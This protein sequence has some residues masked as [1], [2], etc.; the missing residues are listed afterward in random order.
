MT[1]DNSGQWFVLTIQ[2]I[3]GVGVEVSRLSRLLNDLSSAF[4]AIARSEIGAAGPRPGRHT[5]AEETLAGIR[6]VR[7][8]PGSAA[9]ELAPPQ[10]TD[11]PRLLP[12]E[13]TPDDVAFGFF[14]E[15]DELERGRQPHPDRWDVRKRVRAVVDDA[16]QIGARAEIVH[17]PLVQGSGAGRVF[18]RSFRTRDIP[19][20]PPLERTTRRRKLSGHTFMV[21]VEPTKQRLRL[22]LPDG[23]DLTLEADEEIAASIVAAIDHVVE[24]DVEEELEGNVS[25]R[26]VARSL[27]VLP[28]SG[29]GSDRPPKSI[30]ELEHEQDLGGQQP[31]YVS[32]ASAVWETEQELR[33]FERHLQ[34]IRRVDTG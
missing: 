31:D 30:E 33:E 1:T 20:V 22:K 15:I 11:Q 8:L 26:R 7:I 18:T 24:I 2:D 5:Q 14:K 12:D 29:P 34:E 19:E 23:R 13:L 10:T 27:V 16:G 6:L 25:T 21:D 4:Y 28:T 32:L 3:D 9:I 17:R